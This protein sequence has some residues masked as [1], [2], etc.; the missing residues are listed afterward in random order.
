MIV[1]QTRTL[2]FNVTPFAQPF[3]R[4]HRTKFELEVL[5]S[6]ESYSVPCQSM[7]DV[8]RH[9]SEAIAKL[10]ADIES[11]GNDLQA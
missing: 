10:T 6:E 2:T 8:K 4:D 3:A 7:A 11:K 5:S 9:M 1:P